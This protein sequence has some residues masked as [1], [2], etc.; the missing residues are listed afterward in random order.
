MAGVTDLQQTGYLGLCALGGPGAEPGRR[1]RL[2]L[3]DVHN[4]PL[5]EEVFQPF[6]LD[7]GSQPVSQVKQAGQLVIGEPRVWL[8]ER[9]PEDD[10]RVMGG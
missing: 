7:R 8:G 6:Y 4:R 1:D 5:D 9:D 3:G 10:A 2:T